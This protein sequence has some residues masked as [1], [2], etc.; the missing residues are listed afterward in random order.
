M[1]ELYIDCLEAFMATTASGKGGDGKSSTGKSSTGKSSTGKSSTG[2]SSTG[3]SST[4]KSSTG[5]SS[6]GKGGEC[7]KGKSNSNTA[8]CEDDLT[9]VR[10]K[11]EQII[12][13]QDKFTSK[14]S[15]KY[16]LLVVHHRNTAMKYFQ[17][18][19]KQLE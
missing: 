5:K 8:T 7:G 17:A 3:K 15:D 6:A 13:T 16:M 1:K 14:E 18:S 19:W 11:K 9:E 10:M 12:Y 4:G 2:E